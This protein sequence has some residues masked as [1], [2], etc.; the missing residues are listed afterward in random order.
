MKWPLEAR[1]YVPCPRRR[2]EPGLVRPLPSAK[3]FGD[4]LA[5]VQ[6]SADQCRALDKKRGIQESCQESA[7]AAGGQRLKCLMINAG[8]FRESQS[9]PRAFGYESDGLQFMCLFPCRGSAVNALANRAPCWRQR[10]RRT[11]DL[12]LRFDA[13]GT[14]FR[15]LQSV[16]VLAE[17]HRSL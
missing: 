14:E 2:L 8:R 10:P 13:G 16:S 11:S 6:E 15:P 17:R 4:C 3:M 7:K 12:I 1:V 9:E 5:M